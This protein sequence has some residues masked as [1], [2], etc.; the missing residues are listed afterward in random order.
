MNTRMISYSAILVTCFHVSVL[1][2]GTTLNLAP[3]VEVRGSCV[4]IRDL[5]TDVEGLPAGWA[6]R[7]VVPAP[8]PGKTE[9]LNLTALAYALQQYPDMSGVTLRGSYDVAVHRAMMALDQQS[10]IQA[11]EQYVMDH[12]P[13][14][15]S[16]Q[17]NL[18]PLSPISLPVGKVKLEIIGH[19]DGRGGTY[20]FSARVVVDD[21]EFRT[22]KI[23]AKV[24]PLRSVWVA[25]RPL[26]RGQILMEEDLQQRVLPV[27]HDTAQQYIPVMENVLGV[28]VSR[29]V[30]VGQPVYRHMLVQPICARSGDQIL[31]LA[32]NGSLSVK[33]QAQ[34]LST[35]RRG[36]QILCMNTASKRRILVK[37]TDPKTAI[38]DF[39]ATPTREE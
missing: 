16:A 13:W 18:E 6:D 1:A 31:V 10:L 32:V 17:V 25:A 22:F 12:E 26:R 20:A 3:V 8:A 28:E 38:V 2:V 9:Q 29:E 19:E 33:L 37:L 23:S 5:V 7:I 36:D 21:V 35:G 11:L 4:L 24:Y 14:Q 39:S 27:Q 30:R 15:G 34:A